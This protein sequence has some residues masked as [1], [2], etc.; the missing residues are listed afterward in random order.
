VGNRV[1]ATTFATRQ[2]LCHADVAS[3]ETA[4]VRTIARTHPTK[5]G[6]TAT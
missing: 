5:A 4:K 2:G 1:Q 6:S 3:S